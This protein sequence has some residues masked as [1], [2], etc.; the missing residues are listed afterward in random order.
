[1]WKVFTL[2]EDNSDFPPVD[3]MVGVSVR[4]IARAPQETRWQDGM[5]NKVWFP[6]SCRET[7]LTFS[8]GPLDNHFNPLGYLPVIH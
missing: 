2:R 7:C 1:M 6:R 8:D 5:R 4:N 3:M